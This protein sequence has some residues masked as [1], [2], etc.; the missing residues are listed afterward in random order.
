MDIEKVPEMCNF[1]FWGSGLGPQLITWVI[2]FLFGFLLKRWLN[3]ISEKFAKVFVWQDKWMKIYYKCRAELP[4]KY[5]TIQEMKEN[6]RDIKDV[7]SRLCQ[8]N[9]VFPLIEDIKLSVLSKTCKLN[10]DDEK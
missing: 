8:L 5:A 9:A 2:L 4:E 6:R 7:E 1:C 3:G 10:F